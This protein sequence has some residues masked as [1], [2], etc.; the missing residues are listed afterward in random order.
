MNYSGAVIESQVDWLTLTCTDRE[1]LIDF[2]TWAR[3]VL[4]AEGLQDNK[5]ADFSRFGYTGVRAG[6]CSW[7]ERAD[8]DMAT[9][10]GDLANL[11]LD[12]A[13]SLATNCSRVDLAVT[14]H[15]DNPPLCLERDYYH[16]YA[17]WAAPREHPSLG[18][19]VQNTNGGSTLYVGSRASD[20]Y[21]RVY[22][23]GA[24]SGDVR[25]K[26]CHRFE[27]EVKGGRAA[28][29]ATE[30]SLCDAPQAHVQA[31]VHAY[32]WEHGVIPPFDSF[33]G[34]RIV[35]GFRRRSDADSKLA[36][37]KTQV[38]PTV[39]WLEE[40]GHAGRVVAALG[41]E[42]EPLRTVVGTA[43]RVAQ[44]ARIRARKAVE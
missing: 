15:F 29:T 30:V 43:R 32:C 14:F 25:Y 34:A 5:P 22:N 10:S 19:L 35:P 21:L 27:V 36:W 38:R 2:R 13:M 1:K 12:R 7:G 6:R 4:N 11:E 8:G 17:E 26:D 41:L 28:P 23:K 44:E 24:E 16:E 40:S 18:V 31:A 33:G 37:L 42:S 20:T 9:L 3:H 39:A